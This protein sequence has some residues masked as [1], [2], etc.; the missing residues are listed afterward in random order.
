M[1]CLILAAGKGSRLKKKGKSKPLI[2]VL[3][4]PLIERVIHTAIEAEADD[5]YVVIGHEGERVLEHQP[6]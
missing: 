5:F 4:I 1:K 3:G 2:P 6:S